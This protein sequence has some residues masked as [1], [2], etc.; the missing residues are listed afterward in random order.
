MICG[1]LG[2]KLGHS[3]SPIIHQALGAKYS[4]GLFEVEPDGLA[5]FLQ[6]GSF[7]GLNVTIPYKKDVIPFCA[8]LSSEA[9]SIGSV[10]TLLRRPGGELYG[11][12][13]D[14]DGFSAMISKSG[15]SVRGK[16]V[17]VLG[18]G[19]SSLTVRYVLERMGAGEIV[20]ISRSGEN[21]YENLNRHSDGQIIVN[22]T[23]VG[24][25]P[26]TD[27]A[28]VSLDAFT[29]LEGVLDII[30][31]P[32]TTRL[33]MDAKEREVPCI[34]GL[35]MLVGQARAACE[36]FIGKTIEKCDEQVAFDTLRRQT[37]TLV[38]IGMPGSG[39]TTVG[40]ILAEKMGREFFD[41]DIVLEEE[42]GLSIPEIFSTEGEAGFRLRETEILKKLCKQPGVVIATGGGCVTRE[43][44]Y[45][46]L[47]QNGVIIFLERPLGML[48][49]KGRPLSQ[50]A[51]L[52][53]MYAAR[54]P[55]YLRL[56]DITVDC[57][58]E[59]HTVAEN[60]LKELVK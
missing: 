10:N 20:I 31:N 11:H 51:D 19:G 37:E 60:I 33:L 14:A 16:K 17:L 40:K 35:S 28:P 7:H 5:D 34:G 55:L 44:N 47:R 1:L 13:T 12:N 59:P 58:S 22:T 57:D 4:Y 46:H 29:G 45:F 26:E 32:S 3:Y 27:N 2:R 49:R 50:G 54:L 48:D 6:N 43:E 8:E 18:N 25:Y 42:A 9:A 52:E 53:K 15:I 38:L 39:K 30:Y 41:A 56:A 24:M 21:N 23:P 36:L